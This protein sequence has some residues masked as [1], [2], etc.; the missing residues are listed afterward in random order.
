MRV[1][2]GPLFI[3]RVSCAVVR[4]VPEIIVDRKDLIPQSDG[5]PLEDRFVGIL[6]PV[7]DTGPLPPGLMYCQPAIKQSRINIYEL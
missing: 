1:T 4:V 5:E 2:K 7:L 3:H 6:H